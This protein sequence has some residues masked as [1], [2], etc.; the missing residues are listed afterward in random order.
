MINEEV[1]HRV[2]EKGNSLREMKRRKA[3][4]I[5]HI[6]HRNCLLKHDTTRRMEGRIKVTGRRELDVSS[7]WLTLR[8]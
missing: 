1:L 2:G 5:D 8:K 7:Y 6:L 4:W 3:K